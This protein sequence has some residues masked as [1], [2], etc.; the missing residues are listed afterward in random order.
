MEDIDAPAEPSIDFIPALC[1]VK[2]G[3]AKEKPE[4]VVLT[5][6]E[7]ARV[8]S[9]TKEELGDNS[10]DDDE[11]ANDDDGNNDVE[12]EGA[13][14]ENVNPEDEFSFG[15]Y[16]DEPTTQVASVRD[17]AIVNENE[18]I[19]DEEDSEAEDEIIKPT[20]N[21]ILVG[22]VQ[23]DAASLEVWVF[24][25]EEE[26]FYT[27]HDFLLPSFPLCIEWLNHDPA[28]ESNGNLCA[29]GCMDP[30]VTIWDL[31]IQDSI[32]PVFKLGSKGN[33]KKNK[34]KFGHTDAVLDL[35]WNT[36]YTHILASASVDKSVI[37]WDLDEGKPHT[38]IKAFK[39]KVQTISFHSSEPQTLLS[40]SSDGVVRLF[41]GRDLENINTNFLK[42]KTDAEVEKVV[43]NP[44][45]GNL[46]V[47][48]T[49]TGKLYYAD[50]RQPK[51]YLWNIDAHPDEISGICFNT[52]IK[53]MLVT[54]GADGSLK[55]WKY[56]QTEAKEIYR[57][58]FQI[59]RIQCLQ[60]CPEDSFTFAIGGE[61]NPR[62]KVYNVKNFEAVRVCF[63]VGNSTDE[64]E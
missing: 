59:G 39:D 24:N 2:R 34:E 42:W 26:S 17:I 28:S 40:G 14:N 5:P 62:L 58:D 9:E 43:W 52:E 8:I 21:L 23:D 33:R 10:D 38:T 15:R 48:G 46:F 22:H 63:G 61:K 55:I 41:D 29:I 20:D 16:D 64:M 19:E 45:D 36:N 3:V 51:N 25:A 49:N 50:V 7:L 60:Q 53:S 56:G 37:L 57:H 1:F 12:M 13:D 18:Q 44:N 6:A 35:S 32:E 47:A 31:D 11:N 30:I 4:K 54:S 27:L